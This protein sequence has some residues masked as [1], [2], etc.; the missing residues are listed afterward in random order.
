MEN[1]LSTGETHFKLIEG[2]DYVITDS[3]KNRY[4]IRFEVFKKMMVS[5]FSAGV[6]FITIN[7]TIL[8]KRFIYKIEPVRKENKSIRQL[9]EEK[10]YKQPRDGEFLS[11]DEIA[12]KLMAD[13]R[14]T[15]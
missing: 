9:A 6:E 13:I 15:S 7:N 5:L 3:L 14:P 12:N 10:Y 2:S 1:G 4:I 11:M 8:N